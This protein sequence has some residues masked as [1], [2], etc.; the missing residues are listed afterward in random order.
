MS[1]ILALFSIMVGVSFA[2]PSMMT[3]AL[4]GFV[5]ILGFSMNLL[6]VNGDLEGFAII[7]LFCLG[8][9]LLL[10]ML[11]EMFCMLVPDKKPP[12]WWD[13]APYLPGGGSYG[14]SVSSYRVKAKSGHASPKHGGEL[15][16]ITSLTTT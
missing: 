1:Y 14:Y 4:I 7:I 2:V 15:Q 11:G 5:F 8:S 10:G 3:T 16:P 12:P 9:R 6:H 13:P